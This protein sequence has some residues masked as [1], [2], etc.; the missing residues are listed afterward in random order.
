MLGACGLQGLWRARGGTETLL[1]S[2]V[3]STPGGRPPQSVP[4][5][6]QTPL[7]APPVALTPDSQALPSSP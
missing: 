3:H 6:T 2:A 1:F 4:T 5:G 7:P